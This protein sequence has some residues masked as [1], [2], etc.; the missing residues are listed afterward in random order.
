MKALTLLGIPAYLIYAALYAGLA[1]LHPGP[2]WEHTVFLI[3]GLYGLSLFITTIVTGGERVR[4]LP[5]SF[6]AFVTVLC[7]GLGIYTLLESTTG[8][9]VGSDAPGGAVAFVAAALPSIVSAIALIAGSDA[10]AAISFG[11]LV[12][13][14]QMLVAI[15]YDWHYPVS[16][17]TLATADGDCS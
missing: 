5:A 17:Y 13:A 10:G 8:K 12:W 16:H 7:P 6:L 9:S 14:I 3:A 1:R 2:T 4:D 15:S 11:W